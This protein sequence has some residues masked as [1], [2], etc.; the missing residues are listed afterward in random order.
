MLFSFLLPMI[1][2]FGG[3]Y[4]LIKL[5]FFLFLHPKRCLG[6]FFR[7]LSVPGSRRALTLAL[8]GTLGVG[9]IFGVAAG[10]MLGGA[11]SVFWLVL[12]SLFS[13]IIKYAE[14][15][16]SLDMKGYGS[17]G[18]QSI[19]LKVFGKNGKFLA[20]AYAV[21]CLLLSLFMG[22]AIQSAAVVDVAERVLKIS[23]AVSI[24]VLIFLLYFAVRRGAERIERVTELVIPITML[25]YVLMCLSVIFLR[26]DYLPGIVN[27]IITEA[28]SPLAVAGGGVG[29]L[30]SRAFYEGFARGILSNEAG[31]GTSSMAHS[32]SDKRDA[33]VGGLFGASEVFFD[34]VVLCPLTALTILLAVNNPS[35]CPTPM[36]LVSSAFISVLG[37]FSGIL[38][39][40]SVF[41]FAYSTIVCWYYY[42]S[43]C[44]EFL[45]GKGYNKIFFCLFSIFAIL[46]AIMGDTYLLG[47]T[48]TVIF[49][50]TLITMALLVKSSGRVRELTLKLLE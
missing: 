4:L 22:S 9:N 2:V 50:M 30:F 26:L 17:G 42:G 28:I 10:I 43:V 40:F 3:V 6:A 24:P 38:L 46:G 11:G 23:P 15:T 41:A 35:S 36:S 37:D 31:A 29:F 14:T 49:F 47:V 32:R 48:D 39:L 27:M 16:I 33:A 45:F 1:I 12:S 19:L 18:M 25:I 5:K 13:M 34:T 21:L 44:L 20:S 8:A 7:E